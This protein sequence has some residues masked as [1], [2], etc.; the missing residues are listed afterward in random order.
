MT[1][2]TP[3]EFVDAAEG[4]LDA[5]RLAHVDACRACRDELT[6]MRQMLGETGG[7]ST[8]PEPSPLFW[9]HM[10]QRVREATAAEARPA[11]FWLRAWRPV[12]LCASAAAVVALVVVLRQA[13]AEPVARSVA[14]AGDDSADAI[15]AEADATEQAEALAF[16]AGLASALPNDELREAARPS[17]HAAAAV[18]EQ[19]T[20]EQQAALVRL[21][22]AEMDGSN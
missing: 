2:F 1:H 18:V 6:A 20:A 22:Q 14:V 9:D 8:V 21:I 12:A 16:I 3:Q 19:L 11:S 7:T 17:A 4:G 5:R 13:P 15:G 10:A